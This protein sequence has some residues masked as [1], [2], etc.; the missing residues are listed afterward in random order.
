MKSKYPCVSAQ[1]LANM[2]EVV[3]KSYAE[4]WSIFGRSF[5]T[6]C[7]TF[8]VHACVWFVNMHIQ[9]LRLTGAHGKMLLGVNVSTVFFFCFC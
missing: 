9:S 7:E 6:G 5:L 1:S 4:D 3:W 8:Q 2:Q